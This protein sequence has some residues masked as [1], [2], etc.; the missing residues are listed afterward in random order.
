MLQVRQ[1]IKKGIG[2]F[3]YVMDRRAIVLQNSINAHVSGK[4][5][6]CRESFAPNT[7]IFL[8]LRKLEPVGQVYKKYMKNC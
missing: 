7:L 1:L 4:D 2:Y 6:F 3:Y 5:P 8:G